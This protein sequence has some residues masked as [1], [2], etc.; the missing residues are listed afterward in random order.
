M[1]ALRLRHALPVAF[2]VL[3]GTLFAHSTAKAGVTLQYSQFSSDST[4]A[5]VLTATATFTVSG[6]QLTIAINNTSQYL[7][8]DLYFNTDTTLTGLAFNTSGATNSNW[9]ISGTGASQSIGAD[10]MGRYNFRITFGSGSSRLAAGTTTLVLDMTGTTTE[11]TIG[12]KL[13]TIPPG[14][15]RTLSVLKFE[16]GPGGDS[17][18]GGSLTSPIPGPTPVPEPSTIALALSGLGPLVVI[19]LRRRLRRGNST[20]S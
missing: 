10:G 5:S 11:A 2:V 6:S 9:G 17:A 15:V 13:S 19:G 12:S 3:A 20:Q 7:I 14:T 8:A 16:A 18:F 4:P 1:D